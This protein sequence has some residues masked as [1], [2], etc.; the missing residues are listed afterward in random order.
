MR[1]S[2]VEIDYSGAT[3]LPSVIEN[4]PRL[5][6]PLSTQYRVRV[7]GPSSIDYR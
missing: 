1:S 2:S 3:P 6:G 5:V 7:T 4:E